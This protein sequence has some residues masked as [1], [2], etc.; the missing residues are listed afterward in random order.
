VEAEA[1]VRTQTHSDLLSGSRSLDNLY[2]NLF[3][4]YRS[5]PSQ[6]PEVLTDMLTAMLTRV[7][8]IMAVEDRLFY[9]R[10]VEVGSHNDGTKVA[11]HGDM[12]F[13]IVSTYRP[14]EGSIYRPRWG[15]TDRSEEGATD[16][17]EEGATDRQEEDISDRPRED[18]RVECLDGDWPQFS[19]LPVEGSDLHKICAV[20]GLLDRGRLNTNKYSSELGLPFGGRTNPT[21]GV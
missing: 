9:F 21:L 4:R 3:D 15:S 7:C 19:I 17:L 10:R 5:Q 14:G 13:V 2:H 12:N 11:G 18:Y 16:R 8:H 20:R 6:T 1:E